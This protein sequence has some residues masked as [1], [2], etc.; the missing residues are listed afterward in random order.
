MIH[1]TVIHQFC[2]G[3]FKEL[4]DDS[5]LFL[6]PAHIVHCCYCCQVGR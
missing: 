2:C 1:Y 4:Y 3:S 5:Y 6:M